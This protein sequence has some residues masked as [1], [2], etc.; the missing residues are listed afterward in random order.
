MA[1]NIAQ[2]LEGLGLGQYAQA[3]AENDV[4]IKNLVL[5]SDDDLK[6]LG[7]SMGHRRTLLAALEGDSTEKASREPA[8]ETTDPPVSRRHPQQ[9]LEK[10]NL[11][12]LGG[13]TSL[14]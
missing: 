1:D 10:M 4:D 14:P 8:E 13:K 5:L 2:W 7:L 9:A 3:F 11:D 12:P 6:E